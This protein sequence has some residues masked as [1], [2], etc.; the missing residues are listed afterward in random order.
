MLSIDI[1]MKNLALAVIDIGDDAKGLKD[2][3]VNWLLVECVPT[4]QGVMDTM[5]AHGMDTVGPPPD[6]PKHDEDAEDPKPDATVPRCAEDR[7]D[8]KS[9]IIH[10]VVIERQP[11]KNMRMKCLEAYIHMY[12]AMKGVPVYLIEPKEKLAYAATTT[13]WPRTTGEIK[14]SYYHR[15]KMSVETAKIFMKETDQSQAMR[16][17]FDGSPKKDDL[18]DSLLQGMAWAHQVSLLQKAKCDTWSA[19]QVKKIFPKK[20][21]PNQLSTGRFSKHNVAHYLKAARTLSDAKDACDRTKALAKAIVKH[22]GT[23]EHALTVLHR[24]PVP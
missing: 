20:P 6:D 16:T 24:L 10:E 13:F 22:F 1:G 3:I 12:F 14:W 19:K 18:S 8:D 4:P 5:R 9:E 7:P 2:K 17:M 23:V 21:T 15:K 11:N